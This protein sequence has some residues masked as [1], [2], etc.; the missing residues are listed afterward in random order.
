MLELFLGFWTQV[1]WFWSTPFIFA[2][3]TKYL[4]WQPPLLFIHLTYVTKVCNGVMRFNNII[5]SV[6]MRISFICW[7]AARDF[8]NEE[9]TMLIEI[10]MWLEVDLINHTLT[11]NDEPWNILVIMLGL[12]DVW[13]SHGDIVTNVGIIFRIL[14]SG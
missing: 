6:L 8:E 5:T 13:S 7:T 10:M 14:S 1:N 2:L 12:Y 11:I 9:T 4:H 3:K